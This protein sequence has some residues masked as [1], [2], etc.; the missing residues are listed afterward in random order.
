MPNKL[1]VLV[2][3]FLISPIYSLSTRGLEIELYDSA[4]QRKIERSKG[5]KEL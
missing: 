1:R 4:A 2:P 3:V 5:E